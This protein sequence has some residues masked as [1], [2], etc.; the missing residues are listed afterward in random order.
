MEVVDE[1]HSID[2]N[3]LWVYNKLQLSRKLNYNC[4]PA[5]AKVPEP[6][7]YIVRPSINFMGMGRHAKIMNLES[8]TEHLHP[9]E[10]WCEMFKGIHY[11]VDYHYGTPSLTVKGCRNLKKSLYEWKSWVKVDNFIELPKILESFKEKYE[12][13][14]CEF[15]GNNL[16][17]AHFRSNSDFRW[18]NT[19]AIPVWK[20]NEHKIYP[21][22]S[23]VQDEDHERLGFWIK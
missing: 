5:G 4:G 10:F 7:L 21:N 18:G 17:E 12:W 16:I 11:S 22:M 23:F 1:F 13:I 9:S 6:G 8:S 14:N 2:V 3:D 19:V 20:T 15:I